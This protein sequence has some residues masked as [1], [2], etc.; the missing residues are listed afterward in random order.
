MPA[1]LIPCLLLR[2]QECVKTV[3]FRSP[4]YLGDPVN[5]VRIFN[6]REVDELIVLDITA[7]PQAL[8]PRLDLLSDLASECFMPLCYGGGIRDMDD[9]HAIFAL[10]VEKVAI[11]SRA[12]NHPSIVE[13]AASAFG[14]QSIVVSIDVKKTLFGGNRVFTHSGRRATRLLP[15]IHAKEMESRG[16]GEILLNSVDRDGTMSGYDLELIRLVA[17]AVNI[18]VVACGG[19]GSL[20]NAAEAIQAGASAVAAGS[21]FSFAG[22]N[23]AVLISY[24]D[25]GEIENVLKSVTHS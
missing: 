9:M 23:R 12:V 1:R 5:I 14:S 25:R 7:T 15:E 22:R 8:E 19:A 6:D 11:N 16:A 4:R 17:S 2:G 13:S 24:P 21:L 3:R 20:E 18:P 10:G